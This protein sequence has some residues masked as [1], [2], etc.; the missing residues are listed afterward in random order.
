V[1]PLIYS[2]FCYYKIDPDDLDALQPEP[3][4]TLGDGCISRMVGIGIDEPACQVCYE[5]FFP[6]GEYRWTTWIDQIDVVTQG[7]A[8]ITILQPPALE[9]KT[10]LIAEAPCIYLIPRG[11][12]IVWKVLGEEV[13]RHFSIDI[14]NPGFPLTPAKSLEKNP[15]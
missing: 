5:D 12:Q 6:G 3:A 7:K 11:T 2:K 1:L 8:E 14:P 9:Q 13:F 15:T 4:P 10:T